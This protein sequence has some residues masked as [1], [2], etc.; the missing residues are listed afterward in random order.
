MGMCVMSHAIREKSRWWEKIKDPEV[1]ARWKEALEE[2]QELLPRH[3]QLT[4]E[5]KE[6]FNDDHCHGTTYCTIG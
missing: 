2:R 3:Q 5:R 6:T 1:M 4:G